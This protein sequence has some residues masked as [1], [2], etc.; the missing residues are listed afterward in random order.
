[1]RPLELNLEKI[2]LLGEKNRDRNF[3]FRSFLK[4]QDDEKIDKIVARLNA[5]ITK[6]IDCTACGNCCVELR[7]YLSKVEIKRLSKIENLTPNEYSE[8]YLQKD[9]LDDASYLKGIPCKYL[10]NKRCTIYALRPNDCRSFP[11][12]HKKGFSFRMLEM[13]EYYSICPIVFN[14]F[15]R[16]KEE[17]QFH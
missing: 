14:I 1:M 15:E 9:E 10:K 11:H 4:I 8:R 13:I 6:Q 17:L 2:V 5:E 3:V 16:L 12:T 7:P